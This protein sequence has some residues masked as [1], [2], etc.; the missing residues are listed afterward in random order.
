MSAKSLPTFGWKNVKLE[1][2][3][4]G[5]GSALFAFKNVLRYCFLCVKSDAQAISNA[6]AQLLLQFL[7]LLIGS[8]N[9]GT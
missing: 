6:V 5:Y 1:E 8:C 4:T 2:R 7:K 9:S 3:A